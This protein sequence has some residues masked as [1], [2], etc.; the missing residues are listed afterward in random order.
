MRN[1]S[2]KSYLMPFERKNMLKSNYQI[3]ESKQI[4]THTHT[5][6]RVHAKYKQKETDRGT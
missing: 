4:D 5:Q 3:I 6:T 2:S 1:K